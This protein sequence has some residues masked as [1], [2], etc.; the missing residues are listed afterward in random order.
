MVSNISANEKEFEFT[1]QWHLT[2]KCDYHCQH[3]YMYD[4]STYKQEL[5]NELEYKTCLKIIDDFYKSINHW[6]IPGRINFT[7]GDPLLKDRF[8]DILEYANGKRITTGIL[9]NPT[10]LD[11]KTAKKLKEAGVSHFQ[12][13]IDG[14][15]ETHDKLRGKKGSFKEAIRAIHILEDV[16][17][18]S[19][20][21][22]TLSKI[23][24]N[25][26]ISV[27]NLVSKEGASG[28]DFA[29]V[30]PIGKGINLKEQM[31]TPQEYRAL[32]LR[33]IEEYKLLKESG[34]RTH[35]G[36]KETLW[37]LLYQELGLLKPL[38]NNKEIIYS[39]CSVG[40][41]TM[42]ILAD[43]TVLACR[44]LPVVIGKVP[45][46]SIRRIFVN[47][48]VLNI[49]RD[50]ASMRKCGKCELV[51]FC[52]GCPAVSYGA[53]GDFRSEDPQCWMKMEK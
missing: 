4:S 25:E 35:F 5:E 46:Q 26:L 21:M 49:M 47:S 48:K 12:I 28:F 41:G 15:E 13:S 9:G 7:G 11:Y 45:R 10:H 51:Q 27:I 2:A 42:A 33:V 36:R 37:T 34:F 8:F 53:S 18:P 30:V 39:G 14:M 32:L 52:R 22:F 16:A 44:R 24:V 1:L 43:G 20:V 50:Y 40:W 3:C 23:N 19:V 38:S 31:L 6:G 17:I 29:R